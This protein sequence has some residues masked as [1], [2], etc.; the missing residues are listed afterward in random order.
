MGCCLQVENDYCLLLALPCGQDQEDVLSQTLLLKGGFITYLQKKQ[1]AGI[2]NV[3]NPGSNQVCCALT[4]MA[5]KHP[6]SNRPVPFCIQV[7]I[8]WRWEYATELTSIHVFF[9]FLLQP[10]YVVQIFPPCEF[11]ESHLCRLAPDLNSIS[12]ISPHLMIVI[13]SV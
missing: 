3:P 8:S 10:A 6:F 9:V 4:V 1:A 13:A 11:S 12:S 2:I 7:N 5:C